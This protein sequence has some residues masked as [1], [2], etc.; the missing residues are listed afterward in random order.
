MNRNDILNRVAARTEPWDIVVIG[1]GATGLGVA[2]DAASRGYATVLFEQH[3]FAKGT[4]SRSTKLIHGGVRYLKQGNISL[5]MEALKERGRLCRN[6]PHLVH[7]LPFIV[8]IYT[9][10]EGPF[11]GVGMRIYD[12]MAG[13]LGLGPST[14]LSAEETRE[15]LPTIEPE[16]LRRGIIYY[17]GQFD[18][19]RLAISLARTLDDVGG[20]GLN[21]VKVAGF[22]KEDGHITGVQVRDEESGAEWE[23]RARVVVNATGVYADAVREMDDVDAPPVV[24]ASQGTHLVLPR[25]FHPGDSAIM[26]PHT[27]DGRVL[28]AVPWHD[29]VIVGTTDVGLTETPLEPRPLREEMEFLLNHS[30]HYLTGHP[31]AS[32]VLSVFSGLRPLVKGGEGSV[33]T[34]ALSR[35]HTV[36]ISQSGLVTVTGGK[37]TT[38]RKMAEDTVNQAELLAGWDERSCCTATLAIHGATKQI[39]QAPHL[40]VYGSDASDLVRLANELDGGR[41]RLHSALPYWRAEVI[42]AVRHEM[43]RT[44]EDVLARRTRALFLHARA[45]MEMAPVV[46]GLMGDE[47]GWDDKQRTDQ[48]R[49]FEELARGYLIPVRSTDPPIA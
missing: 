23:V 22:I 42:W 14:T 9:W 47:L 43:A 46:A 32:D 41:E 26:I 17:D 7:H 10:W 20:Y 29:H 48:V 49:R 28:F 18:D 40:Q 34:A 1:G 19:A 16:G 2:V 45:A 4:S 38:Y 21:Y 27:E 37:W 8:P 30:A 24:A 15:H 11:Y 33:S 25:A 39:P 13:E 35:D 31:S 6:A 3:D 36:M 5:V 44:V 12:R